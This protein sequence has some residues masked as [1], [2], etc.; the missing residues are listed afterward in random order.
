[1]I[2]VIEVYSYKS[3]K[4]HQMMF[5]EN[6]AK[7]EKFIDLGEVNRGRNFVTLTDHMQ[8]MRAIN[9]RL[10]LMKSNAEDYE[11]I[12]E[13]QN[14]P[15]LCDPCHVDETVDSLFYGQSGPIIANNPPPVSSSLSFGGGGVGVV[16]QQNITPVHATPV[17]ILYQHQNSPPKQ[18]Q[19]H[20][21]EL[22]NQQS[23]EL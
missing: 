13:M 10:K 17:Q 4:T 16:P 6:S 23:A 21:Q 15:A 1:M 3:R 5:S 22:P 9:K 12:M 7:L 11:S 2:Y 19:N 18:Q 14:Q 8:L 20:L